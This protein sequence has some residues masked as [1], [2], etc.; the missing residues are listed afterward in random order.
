MRLALLL[1]LAALS[2]GPRVS[3]RVYPR[4]ALAP[5]TL[6][7]T[8]VVEPHPD[9]RVVRITLDCENF[10]HSSEIQLEGENAAKT[11]Q[12]PL[13]EGIPQGMCEVRAEVGTSTGKVISSTPVAI[14]IMGEP[15]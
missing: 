11:Y 5:A 6:K 13:I 4:V 3:V 14:E 15:R 2:G 12:L 7:L 9:N 1:V 10:Y 8:G